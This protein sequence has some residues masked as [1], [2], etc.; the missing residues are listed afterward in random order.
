MKTKILVQKDTCSSMFIAALITM[1][2]IGEQPKCPST[3]EWI[4]KIWC[5]Y[6]SAIKKEWN[7]V[8]CNNMDEPREYYA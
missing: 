8:I 5:I 2:E 3:G 7:S 4:K 1:A 6:Y